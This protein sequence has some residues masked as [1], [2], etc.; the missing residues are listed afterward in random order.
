MRVD[1]AV[2]GILRLLFA[3]VYLMFNKVSSDSE[4]SAASRY[5]VHPI[6][7]LQYLKYPKHLVAYSLSLH[8]CQM[9]YKVHYMTDHIVAKSIYCRIMS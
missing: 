3:A 6:S 9:K 7:Q 5:D 2:E 1:S 8:R 4:V